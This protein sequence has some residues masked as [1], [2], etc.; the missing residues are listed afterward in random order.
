M[1]F[2]K[3][4]TT[5]HQ[6][7]QPL[8][9]CLLTILCNVSPYVKSMSMM[10]ACKL[11]HLLEAFSTPWFLFTNP[12]NHHLV[13]FLLEMFN[14]IS[15]YQFD[16][17]ANLVY[18]VIRKRQVFHALA[19]L[20]TDCGAINKTLTRRGKKTNLATPSSSR[21]LSR[22]SSSASG[23]GS[24][25][26]TLPQSPTSAAN[27]ELPNSQSIE[28]LEELA[29]AKPAP[30]A[31]P[32][33]YKASLME[34][35]HIDKLTEKSSAH[36]SQQQLDRLTKTS[37]ALFSTGDAKELPRP[38]NDPVAARITTTMEK[39]S[40]GP[41]PLSLTMDSYAKIGEVAAP[42][43]GVSTVSSALPPLTPDASPSTL[44]EPFVPTQEW[45]TSWKSKLP[46]QTIMRLLQ[47]LTYIVKWMR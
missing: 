42:S 30:F 22:Q 45:V 11:L 28:P 25:S 47:V 27:Q 17:H 3:I 5:G 14:N 37:A 31:E 4:I 41:P 2:H 10:A 40:S 33:T 36:P 6:R 7:L 21:T 1:V 13:F 8:F 24:A 16:G 39:L 46:L 20:P 38:H 34:V 29:S 35:P 15:Q 23:S 19:N 12:T 18:T 44:H 9:D 32:G 43:A 26:I